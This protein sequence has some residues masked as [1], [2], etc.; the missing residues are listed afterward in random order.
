MSVYEGIMKGLQEA[1]DF[2]EGKIRARVDKISIEPPPKF[3]AGEIRQIRNDLGMTQFIFAGF[4]GVS[5]KTVEAWESG[6]NTP[7]GPARRILS[8]VK[9][10]PG[11]PEKFS[12]ITR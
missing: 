5:T 11:L 12:I 3:D 6:R 10:D 8:M 1:I 9:K 4:I 7:E 2:R